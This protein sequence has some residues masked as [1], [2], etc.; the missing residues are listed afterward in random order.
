MDWLVSD[1]GPHFTV[2]LM[3]NLTKHAHVRHYSTVVYCQRANGTVE[4]LCEELC[5]RV[6]KA[7]LSD[8]RL[9]TQP[10]PTVFEAVQSCLNQLPLKELGKNKGNTECCPVEVFTGKN[11]APIVLQ[12]AP[13]IKFKNVRVLKK[14]NALRAAKIDALQQTFEDFHKEVGMNIECNRTH[15]QKLCMDLFAYNSIVANYLKIRSIAR[16]N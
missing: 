12:P 11:S 1:P 13:I 6:T 14:E 15:A 16:E 4:R 8:W 7:L 3:N 5:Y 2:S 9:R 10:W